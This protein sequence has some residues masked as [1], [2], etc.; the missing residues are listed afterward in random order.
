MDTILRELVE[1]HPDIFGGFIAHEHK[2]LLASQLS[3]ISGEAECRVIFHKL[4]NMN[5]LLAKAI[6]TNAALNLCFGSAALT[7]YSCKAGFWLVITHA[8]TISA[9]LLATNASLAISAINNT[10]EPAATTSIPDTPTDTAFLDAV[11]HALAKV[12]GPISALI[13]ED[14]LAAW[15]GPFHP[16][17]ENRERFL[18]LIQREF[19]TKEQQERFASLLAS[20]NS[21]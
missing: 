4:L 16:S 21:R 11:N 15:P 13:V 5:A 1:T 3:L 12:I 19:D 10:V 8:S 17:A 7:G 2:G 9:D 14:I 6:G 18:Q 20:Q